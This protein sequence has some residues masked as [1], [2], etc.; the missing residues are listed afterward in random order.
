VNDLGHVTGTYVNGTWNAFLWAPENGVQDIGV[1]QYHSD[2]SGINNLDQVTGDF[3]DATHSTVHAFRWTPQTS[4]LQDLGTLPGGATDWFQTFDINDSGEVVGISYDGLGGERSFWWSET[5]GMQEI[6]GFGHP[7]AVNNVGQVAGIVGSH[8]A[9]WTPSGGAQDLGTLSGKNTSIAFGV[10]NRGVAVGNSYQADYPGFVF[11]WSPTQG[12]VNVNSLCKNLHNN[13]TAVAINDAGQIAINKKGG[14]ALLL[15]PII[16]VAASSSQNPS[17]LGQSVTLTAT[18]SSIAG[19]P[20]NGET[21]TFMDS[22]TV[23]GTA[24]LV[25]GSASITL[26]SLGTGMH[27]VR[28]QYAG[29][30]NYVAASSKVLRQKVV[31]P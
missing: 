29:D 20:P 4:A 7:A 23:L 13:W 25:S 1:S 30:V 9:L 22:T 31:A 26:S 5:T 24:P 3:G 15:T 27:L 8:A 6:E 17:H 28:A 14:V 10:N 2:G 11:L 12:M 21:I 19:P 18:A 16:G